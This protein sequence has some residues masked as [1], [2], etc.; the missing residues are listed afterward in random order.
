MAKHFLEALKL[1]RMDVGLWT[2][3]LAKRYCAP[4]GARPWLER[5]EMKVPSYSRVFLSIRNERDRQCHLFRR[6]C[7][8]V[9]WCGARPGFFTLG[10]AFFSSKRAVEDATMTREEIEKRMDEL[11]RQYADAHDELVRAQLEALNLKLTAL[12]TH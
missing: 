3:N 9:G 11:G 1:T 5:E 12:P 7:A 2:R 6:R 4:L 8:C 10:P